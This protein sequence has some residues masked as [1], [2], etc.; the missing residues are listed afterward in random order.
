VLCNEL[1]NAIQVADG[2]CREKELHLLGG[3]GEALN[4]AS[5]FFEAFEDRL[6]GHE[7]SLVSLGNPRVYIAPQ[8]VA[9]FQ[10]GHCLVERLPLVPV[11]TAVNCGSDVLRVFGR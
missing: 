5:A 9:S 6:S 7:L 8:S 10:E 1:K 4:F 11:D 2:E 3:A